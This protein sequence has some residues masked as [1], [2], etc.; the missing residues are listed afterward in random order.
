MLLGAFDHPAL[1]GQHT[2]A[3]LEVSFRARSTVVKLPSGEELRSARDLSAH[4]SSVYLPCRCG[5]V[6]TVFVPHVT[7]CQAQ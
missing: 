4:V 7:V 5:E 1:T 6:R 3:E 2:S